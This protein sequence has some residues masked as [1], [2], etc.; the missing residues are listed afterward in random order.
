MIAFCDMED[1]NKAFLKVPQEELA[2]HLEGLKNRALR[3][4]LMMGVGFYH[5]GK[6]IPILVKFF[7]E[8]IQF[9]FSPHPWKHF[10]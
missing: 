2:P 10:F 3:E 6:K 5:E 4:A 8:Q 1:E 7:P 9:N